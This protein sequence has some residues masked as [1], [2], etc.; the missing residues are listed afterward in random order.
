MSCDMRDNEALNSRFGRDRRFSD[1]GQRS[2]ASLCNGFRL[3]QATKR[4]RILT[5]S[6][7][8]VTDRLYAGSGSPEEKPMVTRDRPDCTWA[9]NLR[10][11]SFD[12]EEARESLERG[13]RGN[14]ML[15]HRNPLEIRRRR[16]S[17]DAHVCAR[18][19]GLEQKQA[20]AIWQARSRIFAW[21]HG[22]FART[23]RST[24]SR[25]FFDTPVRALLPCKRVLEPRRPYLASIEGTGRGTMDATSRGPQTLNLVVRLEKNHQMVLSR[26]EGWHERRRNIPIRRLSTVVMDERCKN[27]RPGPGPKI[28]ANA[29]RMSVLTPE[30]DRRPA[31][32]PHGNASRIGSKLSRLSWIQFIGMRFMLCVGPKRIAVKCASQHQQSALAGSQ[33][34][35]IRANVQPLRLLISSRC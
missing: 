14:L 15:N 5:E 13:D 25:K 16:R 26:G 7:P 10:R 20:T 32:V 2:M 18:L 27:A 4:N 30:E 28:K 8:Y 12:V 19:K 1:V 6:K 21:L 31:S 33:N 24:L 34:K 35:E 23:E 11:T 3:A 17:P 29:G 22:A 9:L